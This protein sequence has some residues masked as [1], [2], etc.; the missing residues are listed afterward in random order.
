MLVLGVTE[1][2]VES[3]AELVEQVLQPPKTHEVV[4]SVKVHFQVSNSGLI[5]EASR[6]L[7]N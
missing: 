6:T 4:R 7:L 1:G 5:A 2:D 3:V